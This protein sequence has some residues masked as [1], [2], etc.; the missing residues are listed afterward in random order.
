MQSFSAHARMPKQGRSRESLERIIETTIELLRKRTYDQITLAEICQRANVSI[1]ALYGR[2][3]GKDELLRAVQVRFLERLG[4]QF[5]EQEM[6]IAATAR[7]LEQ[8]VPAVVTSMGNLLKDNACV[9]RSFMLHGP[10]DPVIGATGKKSA[11][12][13]HDKFANL[14][15]ACRDEIHHAHPVR[16]VH[17]SLLLVYAAQARLLG[18]D[19]IG[20]PTEAD[21][22]RQLLEDLSE[23]MLSYL[24]CVPKGRSV[25][26]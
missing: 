16:A 2:V 10:M 23:M 5:A 6:H 1:G 17:S 25:S 22:W 8:V 11:Q 15:L 7:G 9:L 12:D 3:N 21:G 19:I 13:N 20:G 18:L 24:S 26:A 14:V 4:E